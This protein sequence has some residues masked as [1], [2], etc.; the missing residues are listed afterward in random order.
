MTTAKATTMDARISV[1]GPRVLYLFGAPGAGK[2]HVGALLAAHFGC[3][4]HD[5]DAWL[6][7]DL[8]ASLAAG[9]GFTPEQRDR[10]YAL[11]GARISELRVAAAARAA[12][13]TLVVAQA[14]LKNRHRRML[15]SRCPYAR[16]CWVR[17][18]EGDV[19]RRLRAGRNLVDA[20][21]GAR[22]AAEFEEPDHPH[23]TIRNDDAAEAGELLA[24]LAS[25]V[26]EGPMEGPC[27]SSSE[28]RGRPSWVGFREAGRSSSEEVL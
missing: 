18:A 3:A 10:Y 2:S 11:V 12:P 13:R 21:L 15:L 8:S 23:E 19:A 17:A 22:M 20:P 27:S 4:F 6:P 25:L 16:M 24:T 1:G 5:A 28:V 14:T 26:Q 7:D 9:S